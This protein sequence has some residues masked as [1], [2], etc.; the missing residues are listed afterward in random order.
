MKEHEP[1]PG[2]KCLAHHAT[3]LRKELTW[4]EQ[5]FQGS[6]VFVLLIVKAQLNP[7]AC[8]NVPWLDG[9]FLW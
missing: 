5:E 9:T 2:C 1:G 6:R 7:A 3:L 4:R 8:L